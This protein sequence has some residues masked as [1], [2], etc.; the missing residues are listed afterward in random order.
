MLA[1]VAIISI[2]GTGVLAIAGTLYV[3][4]GCFLVFGDTL[5]SL[6]GVSCP[7]VW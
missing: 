5:F 2:L 3:S 7:I 6:V 1:T 4:S